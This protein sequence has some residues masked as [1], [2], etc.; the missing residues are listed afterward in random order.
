MSQR[1][2]LNLSIAIS[3]IVSI[4]LW[5]SFSLL[6]GEGPCPVL[7]VSVIII[8]QCPQFVPIMWPSPVCV[9]M[10]SLKSISSVCCRYYPLLVAT[11]RPGPRVIDDQPHLALAEIRDKKLIWSRNV[12]FVDL[13]VNEVTSL[14]R[15]ITFCTGYWRYQ[16]AQKAVPSRPLV[17]KTQTSVSGVRRW[18]SH[19]R[20]TCFAFSNS[21]E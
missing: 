12:D 20:V 9:V 7:S 10:V 19:A 14:T 2:S 18:P 11:H 17:L 15:T 13:W 8:S 3:L 16:S 5:S 21:C 1:S 6:S 4:C